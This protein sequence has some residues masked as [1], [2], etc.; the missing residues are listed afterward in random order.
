MKVFCFEIIGIKCGELEIKNIILLTNWYFS[1][2]IK[3]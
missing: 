3:I 2:K 1:F